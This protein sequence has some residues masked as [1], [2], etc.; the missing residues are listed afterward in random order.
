MLYACLPVCLAAWLPGCLSAWLPVCV[1]A[2]LPACL[3]AWL[4]GC[5]AAWP[6]DRGRLPAQQNAGSG[7][8]G[9]AWTA[10]LTSHYPVV[11][12]VAAA[13]VTRGAG[14]VELPRL[15]LPWGILDARPSPSLNLEWRPAAGRL[16]ASG[17][18]RRQRRV[19]GRQWRRRRRQGRRRQRRR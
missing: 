9:R 6:P 13:T 14:L 19:R 5:L 15:L 3:A 16:A 10:G 12:V 17:R 2:Q 7:W 8:A 11:L 4:T 18:E 1:A